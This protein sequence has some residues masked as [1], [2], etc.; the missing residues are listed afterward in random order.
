MAFGGKDDLVTFLKLMFAGHSKRLGSDFFEISLSCKEKIYRIIRNFFLFGNFCGFAYVN[1]FTS[2]R[3]VIFLNDFLKIIN[4]EIVDFFRVV[5]NNFHFGDLF[6]KVAD[7]GC[8]LEYIFTVKVA[9]FYFRNVFRLDLVDSEADHKV[10]NNFAFA[11]GFADNFYRLVNIKKNFLKTFE[12]MEFV[13]FAFKVKIN[14]SANTFVSE[15][16]PFVDYLANA[17]DHR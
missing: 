9:E 6:F 8:A 7:V 10:G 15:C 11:F 4:N 17:E 5:K 1:N 12:E 2:S 14:S 13:F 16:D 3:L